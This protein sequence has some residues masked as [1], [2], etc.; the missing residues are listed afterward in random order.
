MKA[1]PSSPHNCQASRINPPAKPLIPRA[2]RDEQGEKADINEM[3]KEKEVYIMVFSFTCNSMSFISAG[4]S[5]S[6]KVSE[7]ILQALNFKR[8]NFRKKNNCGGQ[9]IRIQKKI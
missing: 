5:S 6:V 7:S 3:N 4:T 9:K 8:K 2:R 1:Q